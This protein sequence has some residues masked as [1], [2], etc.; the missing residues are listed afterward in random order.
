VFELLYCEACGELFVG[1]MRRKRSA[2]EFELLP[3]E[4]D[5]DGLPDSASSQ[6]FEDLSHEQYCV[7]WPT[8][9]TDVPA[10]ATTRRTN[11]E[12]W[13]PACLDGLTGVARVL[14]ATPVIPD[15]ARRGWLFRRAGTD[16]DHERNNRSAGT[17]VSYQCPACATDYSPRK[18]D[19]GLRLSPV[20]HFRTGFAKTTQLLASELFDFLKLHFSAAK[21]VSFSDSRQDAAKA[22]LDVESRHHEDVRRNILFTALRELQQRMPDPAAIDL[23]LAELRQRRRDAEDSGD[24]Q[25]E[26][27]CSV[28]IAR[29]RQVRQ[30]AADGTI[31]ISEVIEDHGQPAVFLGARNVRSPLR[32]LIQTFVNL[33]IHPTHP[34][35]TK[36]FKAEVGNET[37]WFEWHELFQKVQDSFDWRDDNQ[38]QLWLD[39]ARIALVQQMQSLVTGIL[40]SRTYFSFEEAGLG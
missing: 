16:D 2:T 17:N 27:D 7:F 28:Q 14:G 29:L 11:P 20:R 5:L 39:D 1:G 13:I 25:L 22:A 36:R 24:D 30:Q 26:A 35:G 23:Q 12:S 3:N 18:K 10:V 9:S 34:A 37:Q 21:L 40:F 33:G 8:D 4:A 15:G 19:S 32:P 38:R 31:S 6:R